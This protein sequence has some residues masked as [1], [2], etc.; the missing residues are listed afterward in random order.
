MK[1][2]IERFCRRGDSRGGHQELLISKRARKLSIAVETSPLQFTACSTFSASVFAVSPPMSPAILEMSA[3]SQPPKGASHSPSSFG[4]WIVMPD[5]FLGILRPALF[6][7][8]AQQAEGEA[9]LD[10][11]R[12]DNVEELWAI[13][14][15]LREFWRQLFAIVALCQLFRVIEAKF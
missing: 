10:T 1:N 12:E 7:R 3:A 4:A 14:F 2:P 13:L 8:L 6:L 15:E 5:S 9:V 11:T